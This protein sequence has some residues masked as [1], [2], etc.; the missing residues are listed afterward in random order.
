MNLKQAKRLRKKVVYHPALEREY[1]TRN[2]TVYNMFDSPRAM[3]H[4]AKKVYE[5]QN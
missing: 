3:Y 5:T 1:I 4:A 2:S